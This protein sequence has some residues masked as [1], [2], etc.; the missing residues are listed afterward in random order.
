MKLGS[1]HLKSWFHFIFIAAFPAGLTVHRWV[2]TILPTPHPLFVTQEALTS[3]GLGL[4]LT[5]RMGR[6]SVY[7]VVSDSLWSHDCSLPGSS[8]HGILPGKN[9]GAGCHFLL[10]GIFPTQGSNLH[11][12]C[13]LLWQADSLPLAPPGKPN[14]KDKPF[15]VHFCAGN[16]TF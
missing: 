13:L 6:W 16:V 4:L 15:T 10:R 11:L 12:L 9:T 2:P 14:L 3:Q 8:V 5:W 7:S 1:R